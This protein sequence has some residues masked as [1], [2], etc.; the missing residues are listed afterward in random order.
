MSFLA[1]NLIFGCCNNE[2]LEA[3]NNAIKTVN[4]YVKYLSDNCQLSDIF[5]FK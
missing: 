1:I 5:V 4:L 3:D 2:A